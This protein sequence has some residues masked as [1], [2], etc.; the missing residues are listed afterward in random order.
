MGIGGNND[1]VVID[2]KEYNMYDIVVSNMIDYS[3]FKNQYNIEILYLWETD[4]LKNKEVCIELIKEYINSYGI[5]H[6]YHSFNYCINNGNLLLNNNIIIPYQ[7]MDIEQ[8]KQILICIFGSALI[9]SI[10]ES[11]KIKSLKECLTP[12]VNS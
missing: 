12:I 9:N 10:I 4:I 1:T 5:L 11:L 2:Y 7:D 3:Y 6:N 8:Y